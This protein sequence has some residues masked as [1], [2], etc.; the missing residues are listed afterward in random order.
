MKKLCIVPFTKNEYPLIPLLQKKY[1][2]HSLVTPMGIG[3]EGNDISIMHMDNLTGHTFSNS[4]V[5]GISQADLVLITNIPNDNPGLY[6]IALRALEIAI[7]D[8]K[9]IRC[10]L[11]IPMEKL[12]LYKEEC[13]TNHVCCEFKVPHEMQLFPFKPIC[14]SITP[15]VIYL[16]ETVPDCGGYG[17]FLNLIQ[18]F[19]QD[20]KVV[21]AV[22]EDCYNDIIGQ[23][24][25]PFWAQN[26]K[27]SDLVYRINNFISR[28]SEEKHPDVVLIRLPLPMIKYDDNNPFD[29][30]ITSFIVSQ[31]VHGD[32][33]ICCAPSQTPAIGFWDNLSDN[34]LSKFGYPILGVC[35]DNLRVDR[36]D[37]E[38]VSTYRVGWN[39]ISDE[40]QI[41]NQNNQLSFFHLQDTDLFEQFY[42]SLKKELFEFDFGVI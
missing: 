34:Y 35:L 1:I 29:F 8:G 16:C 15:P 30:G 11:E 13:S 32:G 6:A 19:Q 38:G 12:N 27:P 26:L 37:I 10:Y 7:S 21:L 41:L 18:K 42:Q 28:M 14:D 17:L 2:I 24:T 3:I 40:L 4:I 22:S 9:E 23:V 31:A 25:Y 39:E 33:C 5:K 36:T 20:K